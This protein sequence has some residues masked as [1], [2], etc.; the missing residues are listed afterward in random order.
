MK[1]IDARTLS[2]EA[3]YALRQRV[4]HV[5]VKQHMTQT[6]AAEV[7][8][9]SR[10]AI[11]GWIGAYR[12]GG[13]QALKPRKKGPRESPAKLK[14]WQAA[15]ISN[16]IRDRDPEQLKL[17]F[18]LWT[19]EAVAE[20]I[21]DRFKLKVSV[22][23]AGRY[24]CQWG[25]TPQKPIRKAFEQDSEAVRRWLKKEYPAIAARA[26]AEKAEIHWG[27]EM[28]VRSDHHAGRSYAPRGKTPVIRD[29][30]KRFS[31]HMIA[32]ITNRGTL[33]FMIYRCKF[34][35]PVF[36][37]FLDRIIKNAARP[38]YL[39]VDGHPVHK[40]HRVQRWLAAHAGR[41]RMFLLPA[42][43]PELNPEELLNNDVKTNAVGRRRNPTP[44]ALEKNM[45]SY[46]QATQKRPDIVR[47]YFRKESVRYAA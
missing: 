11:S 44:D 43:S 47:N 9:V 41:I 15:V 46:L 17:P 12:R 39:I 36:I 21:R 34:T 10:G 6:K 23:T 3:Q 33:R 32:T 27:D 30:G 45:R 5:V 20:L 38:V 22:R 29:T 40:A 18:V 24:L 28:G 35:T 8:G 2:A 37:K 4:V 26:R 14:P 1:Q 19:R 13:A 31:C 16:L 25:F 7:F 42:Y